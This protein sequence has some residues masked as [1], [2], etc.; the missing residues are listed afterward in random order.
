ML[1]L[2][3]VFNRQS[4]AQNNHAGQHQKDNENL[5]RDVIR[6]GM[7]GVGWRPADFREQRR[8]GAAQKLV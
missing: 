4:P 8:Y 1:K 6:D 7:D 2:A 5:H 3:R